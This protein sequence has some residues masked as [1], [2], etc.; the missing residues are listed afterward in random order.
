[1]GLYEHPLEDERREMLDA[2]LRIND[3]H[4]RYFFTMLLQSV[5]EAENVRP[6]AT[7]KT[8]EKRNAA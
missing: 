3:A 7:A 6:A 5:A 1:M 8:L 4:V 2:Y